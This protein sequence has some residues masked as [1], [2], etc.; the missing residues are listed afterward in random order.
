MVA[1]AQAWWQSLDEKQHKTIMGVGYV[2][3]ATLPIRR[4]GNRPPVLGTATRP[5]QCTATHVLVECLCT[6]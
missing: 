3:T 2:L 1:Q 4:T 5:L 6:A